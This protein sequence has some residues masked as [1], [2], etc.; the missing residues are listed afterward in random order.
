[1]AHLSEEMFASDEEM[2]DILADTELTRELK[3]AISDIEAE[4]YTNVD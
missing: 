3:K 1:M 4:Q 2:K